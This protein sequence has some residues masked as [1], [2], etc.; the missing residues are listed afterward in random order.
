MTDEQK[1]G[2]LICTY[3]TDE[4]ETLALAEQGA[5]GGVWGLP[6]KMPLADALAW[7]RE[8]NERGPFPVIC[9]GDFELGLAQALTDAGT[10]LPSLMAVGA[11]GDPNC[12]ARIGDTLGRQLCAA[13]V[14][15]LGSPVVDVNVN[16]RNPIINTRAFG[17]DPELVAAMAVAFVDG[18]QRN[19]VLACAKHFPGH[20]DTDTDSHRAL[21]TITHGL[22]RMDQVELLPYRA[23]IAGNVGCIMT[24]HII[25][26]ELDPDV[27]A[28]LSRA[29]LHGL[30]REKLGYDGLIIS[31]ALAMHALSHNYGFERIIIDAVNAGIDLLIPS[32]AKRT[33]G[34]LLDAYGAGALDRRGIDASVRRIIAAKE[35]TVR[36]NGFL[37]E[38]E[39][40]KLMDE[41]QARTTALD[42]TRQ[43]VALCGTARALLSLQR[44]ACE[45]PLLVTLANSREPGKPVEEWGL[46]F[47]DLLG[48][49]LDNLKVVHH[50]PGDDDDL[51]N[52]AAQSDLAVIA[53][54]VTTMA[55]AEQGG[56]LT[57]D[58]Q[59]VLEN[60]LAAAPRSVTVS[61][62]SPYGLARVR[63][64]EA[65]VCVCT[66]GEIGT[67]AVLDVLFGRAEAA[68]TLPQSVG[69]PA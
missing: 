30:L 56:V 42:V 39:A 34:V 3:V 29:V 45:S 51:A 26:T 41:N 43:S 69:L 54:R 66:P 68:G 61:T 1:L 50:C 5:L 53:S 13:G 57:A 9:G 17:D 10:E 38:A 46:R 6:R 23:V 27:P 36:T 52:T 33:Y 32:E 59:G 14:H 7:R 19:R 40:Y 4:A 25:F 37:S 35:Q 58:M 62:G 8:L 2:Q 67:R 15:L 28:T 55:Y 48:A 47:G 63:G 24:S 20:G 18:V 21:P 65:A 60:V 16:P 31:D 49:E 22:E 44:T 12:A 11:T 64:L